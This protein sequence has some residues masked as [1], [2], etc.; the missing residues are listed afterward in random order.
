M[1]AEDGESYAVLVEQ[2]LGRQG[3]EVKLDRG[4]EDGVYCGYVEFENLAGRIGFAAAHRQATEFC[5]LLKAQLDQHSRHSIGDIED[6]SR[7][8]DPRRRRDLELTYLALPILTADSRYHDDAVKEEFRLAL[9]RAGQQ[10]DQLQARADTRRHASRQ[11]A[12]RT[13]LAALLAGDA[14]RHMDETTKKQLL[15]DV[16]AL[17]FPPRGR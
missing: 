5:A 10:W 2:R 1:T 6:A 7:T 4:F 15:D 17:A 13:R 3:L 8:G 14:Y 11:E 9:L 16:A 12:F